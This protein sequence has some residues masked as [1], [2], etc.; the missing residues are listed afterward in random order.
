[1]N[2]FLFAFFC[3]I[4]LSAAS[5]IEKRVLRKVHAIDYSATL[6]ILNVLISAPLLFLIDFSRLRPWPIFLIFCSALFAA[7]SFYLVARGVR[8]LEISTVSPLLALSPGTSSLLAFLFLG[9]VLSFYKIM[10]ILLMILGS[11]IL[12]MQAGKGL[13]EPLR[14]VKKSKYIQFILISLVLYSFGAVFDRTILTTFD[15]SVPVYIFFVHFFISLLY[16]P[17]SWAF[18][19]SLR[20][21]INTMKTSGPDVFMAAIFTVG[22]RYF[23]M[24][25]LALVYVGFVSAIKRS[26]TFF[27]T[28]IGGE[29]FHEEHL[30]RK[31][32]ASAV[33]IAGT[34]LIVL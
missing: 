28:F 17:M 23:Q 22:Y 31:L 6:A 32:L 33:I 34:L 1:M 13:L 21:V 29:L 26:S 18:G 14:I 12:T 8:H 30:A 27:T 20:G 2:W 10:G 9:E 15:V 25:A 16:L 11:Y 5:L 19:G 3:A 7:I 4:F 24:Q